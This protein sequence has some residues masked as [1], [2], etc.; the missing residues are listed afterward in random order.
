MSWSA[1]N[2]LLF[3]SKV[4]LIPTRRKKQMERSLSILM[5]PPTPTLQE[6]R[7]RRE[8]VLGRPLSYRPRLSEISRDWA[9]KR[10]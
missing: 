6:P 7:L 3:R 8:T 1:L 5:P 9:Q 2:L 4:L 10:K